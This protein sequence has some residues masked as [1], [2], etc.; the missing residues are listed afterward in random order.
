MNRFQLWYAMQP[1]VLRV[2][3]VVNVG[4]YLLFRVLDIANN[5]DEVLAPWL[6]YHPDR[7][8]IAPWTLITHA[9]VQPLGG[10]GG[11]LNVVFNMLFLYWIGKEQEELR[12]GAFLLTVYLVGALGGTTLVTLLHGMGVVSMPMFL[13]GASAPVFALLAAVATIEPFRKIGLLLIGIVSLK[14]VVIGFLVLNMLMAGSL[15]AI[16]DTGM[17][18]IFGW[19]FGRLERSGRDLHSWAKVFTGERRSARSRPS[20]I[21]HL[22]S[23]KTAPTQPAQKGARVTPLPVRNAE[24][25]R[26]PQ[27]PTQADIDRILDKISAQGRGALTPEELTMLDA[28]SK[29]R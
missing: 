1:R 27:E 19:G 22:F 2:L 15:F 7:L 9:F 25:P 20:S 17:A 5:L 14:W 21:V 26:S 24:R 23:R 13:S 3:L 8:F 18:A 6:T 29:K 28:F 11:L 12:G 16:I 4:M 10:F